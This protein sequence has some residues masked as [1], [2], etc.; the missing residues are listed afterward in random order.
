MSESNA[1]CDVCLSRGQRVPA[2]HVATSKAA[3]WLECDGHTETDNTGGVLRERLEPL[4]SWMHRARAAQSPKA[5]PPM[6]T[7]AH[8]LFRAELEP[9]GEIEVRF[10]NH[11]AERATVIVIV[12]SPRFPAAPKVSYRMF[13]VEP[14]A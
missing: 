9:G 12:S 3:Q 6:A 1:V 14:E 5:A 2:T 7:P 8:D 10:K 4:A 13:V 11:D